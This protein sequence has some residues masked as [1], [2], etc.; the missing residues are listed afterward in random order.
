VEAFQ[1]DNAEAFDPGWHWTS[2]Q[3]AGYASDAWGQGFDNG[4]Q[5][6]NDKGYKGRVRAVR[7]FLID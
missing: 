1:E 2:T 5:H 6:G 3:Y 7:R 4:S